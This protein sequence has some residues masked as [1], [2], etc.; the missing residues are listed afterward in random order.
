M[1]IKTYYEGGHFVAFDT[2]RFTEELPQVGNLLTNYA[3][4]YDN[5]NGERIW[6]STYYYETNE[7]Y[8]ETIGPTGLPVA[9]RRDGWSFLLVDDM[10]MKTL[11]RLTI[12]EDTVLMRVGDTLVDVAALHWAFDVADDIIPMANTAH[13]HLT[14]T[15]CLNDGFDIDCE[16]C[17]KMGFPYRAYKAL[18]G[19]GVSD[20][21][22]DEAIEPR[23]L[24]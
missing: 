4:D 15:L 19:K 5:E 3:I 11:L 21:R 16:S 22:L 14:S 18:A 17:R 7:R 23:S 13:E 20:E 1:M 10:D 24:F 12:D 6:L 8:R 9:R 2:D